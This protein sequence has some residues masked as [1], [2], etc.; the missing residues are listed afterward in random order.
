MTPLL[1]GLDAPHVLKMWSFT[2]SAESDVFTASREELGSLQLLRL[3]SSRDV[4][5]LDLLHLLSVFV[6]L[7]L[8]FESLSSLHLL[9]VKRKF[10]SMT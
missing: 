4:K 10:K 5:L 6:G 7:L 9:G 3:L 1:G 8:L 2:A